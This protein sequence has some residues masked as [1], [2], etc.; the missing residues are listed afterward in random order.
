DATRI[1]LE[2]LSVN[3]MAREYAASLLAA[4]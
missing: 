2:T 3:A 4:E 1:E